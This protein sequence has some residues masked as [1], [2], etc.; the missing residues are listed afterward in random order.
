MRQSVD[1]ITRKAV[2]VDRG[3][4]RK[5]TQTPA[6]N[7]PC[8]CGSGRK[9]KKCCGKPREHVLNPYEQMDSGYSEEQQAGV[10]AFI[11][12]FG[13]QPNPAQLMTF[14]EGSE[15]E[16]KDTIIKALRAMSER[17]NSDNGRFIY[18]VQEIGYLIT[19]LN[20]GKLDEKT[21]KIWGACL[22]EY[23]EMHE[24]DDSE[25]EQTPSNDKV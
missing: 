8:P 19:P 1:P 21:R 18:G 9:Y 7:K 22:Q 6:R 23:R 20:Q 16:I 2:N 17:T 25:E 14:M 24:S 11:T 10:N 13:F 4:V 3:T 5:Q 15:E 12:K